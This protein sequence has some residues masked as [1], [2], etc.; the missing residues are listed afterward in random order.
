MS[1]D[2]TLD[3]RADERAK[4]KA[5]HDRIF[6]LTEKRDAWGRPEFALP[7]VDA[8]FYGWCRKADAAH[9]S[10]T[11]AVVLSG[12]DVEKVRRCALNALCLS[13]EGGVRDELR[14]ALALLPPAKA[15]PDTAAE[16]GE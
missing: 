16:K 6:D 7:L 14:Q 2:A 9:P 15:M 1:E 5:A 3:H 8:A 11:N 4:F 13:S 10:L 12:E